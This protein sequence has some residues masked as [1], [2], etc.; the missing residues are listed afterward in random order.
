M[1]QADFIDSRVLVQG[2]IGDTG[3][4]VRR[5]RRGARTSTC[6][7]GPVLQATA[8]GV[9]VA[10]VY[11]DYQAVVERDLG[12]KSSIRFALFGSDD[13]LDVFLPTASSSEP[14]LAGTLGT[15]TG[16]WRGQGLYR[17]KLSADTELR[18]VG[19]VGEDYVELNAGS[20]FFNLTEW[21]DHARASSS[22]RSWRRASR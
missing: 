4:K 14:D 3:W 8:A 16:F 5:R 6:G 2:P 11:Y 21:T 1:A 7:C 15:H 10:P 17:N 13:R 9:S 22:R 12:K 19:A 18:V 20:I